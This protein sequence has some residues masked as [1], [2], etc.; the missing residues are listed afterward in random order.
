MKALNINKTN[1]NIDEIIKDCYNHSF[2]VS[3]EI[4][5]SFQR[6]KLDISFD[7][8]LDIFNK[9]KT[10][11]KFVYREIP[12]TIDEFNTFDEHWEVV[13]YTLSKLDGDVFLFIQMTVEEGLKIQQKY[14]IEIIM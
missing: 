1:H 13:G 12:I 10:H 11:W 2:N 4:L 8:C 6:E 9:N 14:D 7:K 3:I 5:H